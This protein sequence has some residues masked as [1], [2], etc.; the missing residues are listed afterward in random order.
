[1]AALVEGRAVSVC[2][3][4]RASEA[5][6]CA[7]VET[8]PVYR[9]RGLAPRVVA[10]WAK[11]VRTR[12]AEPFYATTFDNMASQIVACRLGL[13]LIGSEFSIYG[14]AVQD[15]SAFHPS[16]NLD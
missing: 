10:A 2:A 8:S 13:N 14:E 6:H 4:V 11:L 9:S 5:A 7:G 12:G 15:G 1:V 3:S 16:R